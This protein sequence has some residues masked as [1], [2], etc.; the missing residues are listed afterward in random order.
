M[1]NFLIHGV[2]LSQQAAGRMQLGVEPSYALVSSTRVF[3]RP[4]EVDWG[5]L[6]LFGVGM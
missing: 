2:K 6:T 1:L 4:L 5:M 3:F